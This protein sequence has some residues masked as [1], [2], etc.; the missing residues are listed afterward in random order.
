M[1][2]K[3]TALIV[4]LMLGGTGV[5]AATSGSYHT[6]GVF[7]TATGSGVSAGVVCQLDGSK[8]LAIVNHRQIIVGASG[9]VLY[10][11]NSR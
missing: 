4:G 1:K 9:R 11:T 5:A 8:R 6:N 7:C 3:I 10:F 2:G